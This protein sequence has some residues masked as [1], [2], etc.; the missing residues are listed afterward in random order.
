MDLKE[1]LLLQATVGLRVCRLPSW[2]AVFCKDPFSSQTQGIFRCILEH[3]L[4]YRGN[5]TQHVTRSPV[6]NIIGCHGY[7]HACTVHMHTGFCMCLHLL[8]LKAD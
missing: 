6:K 5:C 7:I 3:S 8:T 2:A 1:I 4:R